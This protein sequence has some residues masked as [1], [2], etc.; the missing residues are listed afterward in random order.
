MQLSLSTLQR[1]RAAWELTPPQGHGDVKAPLPPR[2]SLRGPV[3]AALCGGFA[4]GHTLLGPALP[5]PAPRCSLVPPLPVSPGSTSHAADPS[6]G[7]S[8]RD[9]DP[10]RQHPPRAQWQERA[11]HEAR[12][13]LTWE[14]TRQNAALPGGRERTVC[15]GAWW[16]AMRSALWDSLG[17][18][19]LSPH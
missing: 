9:A 17:A 14:P 19:S 13:H 1:V 15:L 2:S 5:R 12:L 7:A 10:R 3:G 18:P 6:S 16:E 4:R 11:Q 8:L